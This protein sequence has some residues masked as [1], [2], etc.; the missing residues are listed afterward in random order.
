MAQVIDSNPSATGATD[1]LGRITGTL[2]DTAA[3]VYKAKVAADTSSDTIEAQAKIADLNAK[4]AV[5]NAERAA[6]V[7]SASTKQWIII[8]GMAVAALLA[9]VVILRSAK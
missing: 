4:T 2:V 1:W 8:G 3:T 6:A 9:G 7:A 5:V